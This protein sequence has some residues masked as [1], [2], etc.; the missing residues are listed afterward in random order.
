MGDRLCMATFLL[1]HKHRPAEC[2]IAIAAW[3]AFDSPLRGTRPLGSCHDGG[4][5]LWWVVQ[6]ADRSAALA[7]LPPFIAERTAVDQVSEVQ[8]P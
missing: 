5:E 3:K 8:M 1:H 2:A 4:H 7:Q 6:A